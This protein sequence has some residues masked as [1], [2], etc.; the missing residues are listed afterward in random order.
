MSDATGPALGPDPVTSQ[1]APA[2]VHR[3]A[4]ATEDWPAQ[5]TD[6]IVTV[7]DTVRDKTTGPVLR[8]ARGLVVGLVAASLA[9]VAGLLLLILSIRGTH[10]ILDIWVARE[11]AVWVGDAVLGLLFL[12][13]GAALW[14]RRAPA[15]P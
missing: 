14:R 8:A 15:S 9:S 1:G 4:D 5:A 13:A 6:A 3:I 12:A 10:E 7:V 2:S 11:T